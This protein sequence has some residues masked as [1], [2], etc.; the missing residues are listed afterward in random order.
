MNEKRVK[1]VIEI[2]K[3]A[4]EMFKKA[5]R[6]AEKLPL[7]AEK[8]AQ[9]LV[10]K[11]RAEAEEEARQML[12]SSQGKEDSA[13]LLAEAEKQMHQNEQLA[14]RNFDRAVTY[15]ISRVLGRE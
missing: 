12:A 9:A 10:E 15:V 5:A 14:K 1:E 4:D 7:Q 8:D 11:A 2:E 13:R 3:Q 6:E